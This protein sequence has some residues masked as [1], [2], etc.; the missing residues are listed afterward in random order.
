MTSQCSPCNKT[1]SAKSL[2][3]AVEDQNRR[4]GYVGADLIDEVLAA[5]EAAE[6]KIKL[7]KARLKSS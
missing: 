4:Q 6:H 3:E 1:R 2:R 5:L 7:Q